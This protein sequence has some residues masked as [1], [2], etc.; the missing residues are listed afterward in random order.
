MWYRLH[1]LGLLTEWHYRTLVVELSKRGYRT[2]EPHSVPRETS[3]VLNKVF[4]G[5]R[6]QGVGKA[7]VAQA[8]HI[9]PADLDALVFGLAMLPVNGSGSGQ[10]AGATQGEKPILRVLKGT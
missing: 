2:N 10:E 5:L 1:K 3:Q 4:N 8:L 9:S 6:K 7:E